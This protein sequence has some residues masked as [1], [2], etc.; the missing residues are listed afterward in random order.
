MAGAQFLKVTNMI[1]YGVRE[2]ADNVAC[3]MRNM[4][5]AAVR[6]RQE[7]LQPTITTIPKSAKPKQI[8]R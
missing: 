4:M 1:D 3:L 6:Q 8:I 5:F 2:G 7:K